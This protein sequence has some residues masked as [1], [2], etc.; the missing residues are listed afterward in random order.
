MNRR[1]RELEAEEAEYRERLLRARRRED[2]MKRIANGRVVKRQVRGLA[3]EEP[4]KNL[5]LQKKLTHSG[6]E[7]LQ[8]D[9]VF[10]P[11]NSTEQESDSD[12]IDPKV[13][14]LMKL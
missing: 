14:A 11:D 13:K 12:N 10:L 7:R 1:R 6:G 5:N 8:D 2:A 3:L 9:D 4:R